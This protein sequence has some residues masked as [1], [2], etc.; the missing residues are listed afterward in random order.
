MIKPG[1]DLTNLVPQ[2]AIAY[3]IATIL[4]AKHAKAEFCVITS[5]R[6]SIHGPHSLHNRDTLC[7]ALD[8]RTNTMVQATVELIFH[9]LNAALGDQFDVVLEVD[10]IHMEFDPKTKTEG[11]PV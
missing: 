9:D 2:M 3:T 7:R 10:H 11:G 4:Y 1:V 6:D 8:L 5:G